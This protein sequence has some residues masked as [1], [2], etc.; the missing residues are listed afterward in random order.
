MKLRIKHRTLLAIGLW[1]ASIGFAN[2]A[3]LPLHNAGHCS[4]LGGNWTR[5]QPGSG[6]LGTCSLPGGYVVPAGD[7]LEIGPSVVLDVNARD[8]NIDGTVNVLDRG[9]LQATG[10]GIIRINGTLYLDN[11]ADLVVN[12]A[13]LSN[14]GTIL[15]EGDITNEKSSGTTTTWAFYNRGLIHLYSGG[16]FIN[17]GEFL[18]LD[19][20][21]GD[22][23]SES[24]IVDLDGTFTNKP[25]GRANARRFVVHGDFVNEYGADFRTRYD[26]WISNGGQFDNAGSLHLWSARGRFDIQSGGNLTSVFGSTITNDGATLVV[27]GKLLLVSATLRNLGNW[28]NDPNYGPGTIQVGSGGLVHATRR[29]YF[30]NDVG[31]VIDNLGSVLLDCFVVYTKNGSVQGNAVSWSYC[32]D[33]GFNQPPV[34]SWP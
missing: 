33:P 8:L 3:T 26:V 29:T 20:E 25:G 7:T 23:S 32:F 6:L 18:D 2:A 11:Q 28:R 31:A 19:T 21:K 22:E 27:D 14:E 13:W 10:N 5:A 16:H 24:V 34:I 15:A 9:T 1:I 17:K 30:T 12:R 4:N